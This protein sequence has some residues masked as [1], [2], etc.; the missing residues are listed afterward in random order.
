MLIRPRQR[1][2]I[3][4]AQVFSAGTWTPAFLPNL[5]GW[6]DF[7]DETTLFTDTSRTTQVSS[8]GDSIAG[9]TDKSGSGYHLS[10]ATSGERPLYKTGIQNGH[11]VARFD[12]TDDNLANTSYTDFPDAITVVAAVEFSTSGEKMGVFEI[13]AGEVVN[14]GISMFHWTT[15]TVFGRWVDPDLESATFSTS[16]PVTAIYSLT[17][18]GSTFLIREN[19]VSGT[20]ASVSG[21]S[22][23]LTDLV[24]G[25]MFADGFGLNGD[26][27]ELII[28]DAE[29]SVDNHN[30]LGEY[31][32]SKWGLSWTTIT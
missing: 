1:L 6:Y 11:S 24:V 17:C 10:Q 32:A 29:L 9:V 28:C 19:G 12:G 4:G 7:S 22:N 18:D 23:T 21:L 15:D 31:M 27:P 5:V 3:P 14:T 30:R 26:M 2:I 13:G 20:S 25:N 8:D 16:T